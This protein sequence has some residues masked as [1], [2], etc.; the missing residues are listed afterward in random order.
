[1]ITINQIGIWYVIWTGEFVTF[2]CR[3]GKMV[4]FWL[5]IGQKLSLKNVSDAL[6]T[7]TPNWQLFPSSNL[8]SL[9]ISSICCY[10][11]FACLPLNLAMMD[12]Q[13]AA[14]DRSCYS[15]SDRAALL[16]Y[17]SATMG[18]Q[19]DY[20]FQLGVAHCLLVWASP[21]FGSSHTG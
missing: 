4:V 16:S 8:W 21:A 19:M 7:V 17:A 15:Y 9:G 11:R 20:C 12:H 5:M 13:Q 1:M 10:C 3:L 2:K 6:V 18:H 14:H